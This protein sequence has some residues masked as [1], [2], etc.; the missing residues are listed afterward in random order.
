M[1]GH[2]SKSVLKQPSL[3]RSSQQQYRED[4]HLLRVQE[5]IDRGTIADSYLSRSQKTERRSIYIEDHSMR[6]CHEMS[7]RR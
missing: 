5:Q 6:G 2:N 4:H 1:Y 3:P 7:R